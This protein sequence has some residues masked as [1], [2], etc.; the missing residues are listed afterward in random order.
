MF[1]MFT[2]NRNLKKYKFN[3]L[4]RKYNFNKKH[5]FK[6]SSK[7]LNVAGRNKIINFKNKEFINKNSP[8]HKIDFK[9][10]NFRVFKGR[11]FNSKVFRNNNVISN[12]FNTKN[13]SNEFL[14][15][16]KKF[17]EKS[18][19]IRLKDNQ[20]KTFNRNFSKNS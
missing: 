14:N 15:K 13:I 17:Y 2:V 8:K 9:D 3:K 19:K 18:D 20:R 11:D 12:T 5:K 10:S 4:K 6:P 7:Y 16:G 1:R